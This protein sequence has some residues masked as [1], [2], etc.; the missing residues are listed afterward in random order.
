[1]T[2]AFQFTV[3][4]GWTE[5]RLLGTAGSVPIDLWAIEAPERALA[6]VDLIQRLI[7]SN[8]A[9][10]EADVA[11]IEHAAIAALSAREADQIGLP[12]AAGV[13]AELRFDGFITSPTFRVHLGWKRPNG[14]SIVG[15]SRTGAWLMFGGAWHRLPD[16]LFAIAEAVDRV[17]SA[18]DAISDRLASMATLREVLPVAQANGTA[19]AQG[20]AGTLRIAVAYSFSLDLHGDGSDVRLVPILHHAAGEDDALLLDPQQQA[21]FGDDQF[22]RFSAVRSV[23]T[24]PGNTFVVLA[25]PLRRALEVVRSAQSAPTARR[26]ALF[27]SPRAFLRDTLGGRR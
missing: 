15:A 16:A 6:G 7:A 9:I 14:Q 20:L 19:N 12:P 23:Y 25:P 2:N 8:N 17:G 21:A 18:G 13:I 22:N 10:S 27:R 26:R 4:D 1:M 11:F 5:L 3:T 24:L